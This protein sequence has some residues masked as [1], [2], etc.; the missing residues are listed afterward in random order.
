MGQLFRTATVSDHRFQGVLRIQRCFFTV[1]FQVAGVNV[2]AARGARSKPIRFLKMRR[3]FLHPPFNAGFAIRMAAFG[4]VHNFGLVETN[5]A[6]QHFVV[7]EQ[8]V[9]V[10]GHLSEHAPPSGQIQTI[11][12][13]FGRQIFDFGLFVGQPLFCH[14][15][16]QQLQQQRLQRHAT[17][18]Q[19]IDTQQTVLPRDKLGVVAGL[20]Q[21]R[22]QTHG[23]RR[24][25]QL[26]FGFQLVQQHTSCVCVDFVVPQS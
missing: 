5:A 2:F 4:D 21:F 7:L 19:T 23:G 15:F 18:G 6:R 1:L 22:Q 12:F 20:A 13:P 9:V 14:G 10:S 8:L 11:L 26:S 25:G 17:F 3:V 16:F 24:Q